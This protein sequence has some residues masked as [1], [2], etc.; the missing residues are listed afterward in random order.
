M[1]LYLAD[2]YMD[3]LFVRWLTRR[4]CPPAPSLWKNMPQIHLFLYQSCWIYQRVVSV[5]DG[6]ARVYGL[7]D[8]QAGSMVEC[9]SGVKGIALN[10]DNYPQRREWE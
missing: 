1:H 4:T 9:P 7:N 2:T 6:I 8:M 5:V 3:K 10:L